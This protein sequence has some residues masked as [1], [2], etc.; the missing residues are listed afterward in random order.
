MLSNMS[1]VGG[2]ALVSTNIKKVLIVVIGAFIYAIG[3]NFFLVP[4]NVYASGF[5]GLSQLLMTIFR[6]FFHINISMG[7]FLL[8]L[9]IP[10][11][12]L[13]WLKLGHSFT[14]YSIM[15]VGFTSFFLQVI[16][17]HPVSD[18]IILNAVFG[19]TISAIGVG[20][21]LRWGASTG[22]M[23]IITLFLSK[24]KD[25]PIG[26]YQMGLNS[27]IILSAGMLFDWEKAL[28][29][30]VALY[31]SSRVVDMI[32]TQSQ[33]LTAMIITNQTEEMKKEIIYRLGRGIT[34][35]PAQGAY[36]DEKRE[37]LIVVISKYELFELKQIIK[38]VD[39]HSF[40]NIVHTESV[41]G[42]FRRDEN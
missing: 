25:Q 33:K 27:I 32:H 40:T 16:P 2:H 15:S 17:I 38:Q 37:M 42:R 23:D 18:D 10:V 4:A 24:W 26:K 41:F 35:L 8:L 3:I 13:S 19:G 6:N 29:T 1:F 9:N 30:M 31:A 11:I 14:F 39:S 5:S 36:S 22:G 28:Y 21:T 7:I 20:L 12:I 34:I